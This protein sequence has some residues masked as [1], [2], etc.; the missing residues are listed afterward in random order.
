MDQADDGEEA[1]EGLKETVMDLH[2]TTAMVLL[3]L[4]QK[5]RNTALQS[6]EWDD[7]HSRLVTNG[8]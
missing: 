7:F 4:G 1:D 6:M 8:H 5:E 3:A 2:Q